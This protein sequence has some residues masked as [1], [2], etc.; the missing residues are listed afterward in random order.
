MQPK[1]ELKRGFHHFEWII[2]GKLKNDSEYQRK[3]EKI[4]QTIAANFDPDLFGTL[5]V[6]ERSDGTMYV[7]DGQQRLNAIRI[8]GWNDQFV[9]CLVYHGLSREDE[10]AILVDINRGRKPLT[11]QQIFKAELF[12]GNPESLAI[13]N[14]VN[15]AGF[16]LNLDNGSLTNGQIC[17]IGALEKV[18]RRSSGP[19][20]LQRA[21]DL[22]RAIWGAEQGPYA[23][24]IMALAD[25]EHRYGGRYDKQRLIQ[26]CHAITQRQ[27]SNSAK[28]RQHR[29]RLGEPEAIGREIVSLYNYR[30]G[31]DNRLEDWDVAGKAAKAAA[32]SRSSKSSAQPRKNGKFVAERVA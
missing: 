4:A 20:Y 2:A 18:Y 15:A 3:V 9:P 22:I 12:R 30:R 8:M 28:E 1:P 19:G 6:S 7:M 25:F 10:A 29:D 14:I 16:V 26:V 31:E 13:A 24:L 17:G 21:L 23:A 11:P 5:L 27:L 32:I